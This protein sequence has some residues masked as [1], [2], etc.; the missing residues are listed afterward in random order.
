MFLEIDNLIT[1]I[2]TD[3]KNR[4]EAQKKIIPVSNLTPSSSPN[5]TPKKNMVLMEQDFS[6]LF[7]LI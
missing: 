7:V 3:A 6:K 1:V 4:E 5:V 2:Q